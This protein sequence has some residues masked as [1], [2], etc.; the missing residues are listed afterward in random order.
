MILTCPE[1]AASYFA[2]DASIG[3][4][5]KVRCA[6]CGNIWR[7]AP[8]ADEV[9]EAPPPPEP[10]VSAAVSPPADD[11]LFA[12]PIAEPSP[13]APSEA[14]VD[15]SRSERRR[16]EASSPALLWAGLG[17]SIA[18]L[19]VVG[20]VF[21]VDIVQLWPKTAGTYARIGLPVNGVGLT[22]EKVHAQPSLLDGRRALVVSGEMRNLR[23][24][25]LIAPPISIALLDASGR[26]LLVKTISAD[27]RIVPPGQ[28]RD[29]KV[30]LLNPPAGAEGLDV[31]F[32]PPSPGRPTAQPS[33]APPA[34]ASSAR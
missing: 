22:I 32:A 4:G 2:D 33:P 25:T 18:L 12:E 14:A 16:R 21:R 7:A 9:D 27:D 23:N 6:S 5:R 3:A 31:T 8:E 11:E 17:A 34:V 10:D 24:R 28:S 30:S 29:F 1:C 19:L 26:R 15:V 13:E 20:L